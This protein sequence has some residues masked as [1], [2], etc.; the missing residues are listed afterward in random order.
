[1]DADLTTYLI[2]NGIDSKDLRVD[3]DDRIYVSIEGTDD[4]GNEI[5]KEIAL[6]EEFQNGDNLEYVRYGRWGKNGE[7]WDE[8]LPDT[9]HYGETWS[10]VSADDS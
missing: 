6:P 8:E 1:M 9:K 5:S 10:D 3:N 4:D 2:N 7:E